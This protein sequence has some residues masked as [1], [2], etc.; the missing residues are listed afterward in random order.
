MQK[1]YPNEQPEQ[2]LCPAE[3]LR[4]DY[5]SWRLSIEVPERFDALIEYAAQYEPEKVDDLNEQYNF[6]LLSSL[7]F[8]DAIEE[9]VYKNCK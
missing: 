1:Q 8:M 7:A 4:R 3:R 5:V 6:G 9:I 2:Y